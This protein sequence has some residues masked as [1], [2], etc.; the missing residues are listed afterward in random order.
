[1]DPPAENVE[2]KEEGGNEEKGVL[3]D[4]NKIRVSTARSLFLYINICK[5]LLHEGEAEVELS[6]LGMAINSVVSCAEILKNQKLVAVTKISTSLSEVQ[7]WRQAN[8]PKLQVF[9][10]KSPQFDEIYAQQL[11]AKEAAK[12]EEPAKKE[13]PEKMESAAES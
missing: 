13:E 8:V 1:M 5:R 3:Q 2:K 11:A 9:V 12:A 4:S 10:K 6:G 7:E